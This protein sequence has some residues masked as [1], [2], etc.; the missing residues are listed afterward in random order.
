MEL[1]HVTTPKKAKRYR[2]SGCIKS[3]VRGFTT[4]MAAMAWAIKTGRTVIYQVT[5]E[6]AY[7]LSDHHNSF[8]EA[9]WIDGDV[10]VE[11]IVCVFSADKD[12]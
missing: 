3:P 12:A 5:G 4:V 11:N 9:W 2:E 7:K 1:Y 8:G 6:H 10:P